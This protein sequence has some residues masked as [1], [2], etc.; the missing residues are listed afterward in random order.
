VT[1]AAER[2]RPVVPL[3]RSSLVVA[4][5]AVAGVLALIW[6]LLLLVDVDPGAAAKAMWL[7]TFGSTRTFGETLVRAT[8]LLL[9]AVALVPSLK[10]GIYNIGAPGQMGAGGLAATLVALNMAEAS[11]WLVVP[12]CAICGCAAGMAT[13][14]VPGFLKARWQVSEIVSSLAINFIVVAV[15]GYLLNGPMQ[16][17]FANL[18]QSE[19][20]PPSSA[21]PTVI[22]HTRAHIGL[23]LGLFLVPVLAAV[24][25]SRL[26]YRLRLFGANATLATQ[27]GLD[28]ARYVI[29]LVTIGG[30]GAGL[31]GWIQVAAIDHRLY[32]GI[33][34]P[35]GY[36]GLFVAL[37]GGLHPLG[38]VVVA[39]LLGVLLQ[40]G[41]SLQVGAGV[42]PEIVQVFL[43]LILFVYASRMYAS[44]SARNASESPGS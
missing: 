38:I 2:P 33:A 17:G 23:L 4:A 25:R 15:L 16:S 7:G 14:F 36:A 20:L 37:L 32:P 28:P 18:P 11:S 26:G 27:A 8:P 5:A 22:P 43:G 10:A 29:W 44:A 13:A 1:V 30:A 42:S 19:P 40:G 41:A 35:V 24:G 12:L 21:L 31:A 9:I 39:F 34:E 3:L 6:G